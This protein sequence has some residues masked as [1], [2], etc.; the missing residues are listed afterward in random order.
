MGNVVSQFKHLRRSF[1]STHAVPHDQ[2]IAKCQL[3][4]FAV[5]WACFDRFEKSGNEDFIRSLSSWVFH[6]SG[7]LRYSNVSHHIVGQSA[8]PPFYT[9]EDDVVRP[10]ILVPQYCSCSVPVFVKSGVS[11][12]KVIVF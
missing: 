11:L 12:R 10:K 5:W 7:V 6:Q 2:V 3:M 9:I 1:F 4:L 8:P